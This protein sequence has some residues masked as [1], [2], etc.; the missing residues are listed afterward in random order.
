MKF[1]RL[2]LNR[3]QDLPPADD[4]VVVIDVLRSFTT[5]AVALANGA[6]AIYP[7]EGLSAALAL[8]AVLAGAFG[9]HALQERLEPRLL[10]AFMTGA[11]YQIEAA[12]ANSE[13]AA[14]LGLQPGDPC[15]VIE[16]VS[17]SPSGTVTWVR[18]VHPGARHVLTG[19]F[20]A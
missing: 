1:S 4:T 11:Q 13:Q 14:A 9:A 16:R 18:L 3:L 17:R 15:L 7:V 6:R 5:A 12:A 8:V 20:D 2:F 19:S 10:S